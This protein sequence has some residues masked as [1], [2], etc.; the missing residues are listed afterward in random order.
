[1]SECTGNCGPGIQ[2]IKYNC[3]K[4]LHDNSISQR[5][6]HHLCS[7]LADMPAEQKCNGSCKDVRWSYGE[8]S[9]CTVTCGGGSQ[10]RKAV[11][12]SDSNREILS[13]DKC[14]S[15]KKLVSRPCN[16]DSCPRWNYA[17][18]TQVKFTVTTYIRIVTI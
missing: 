15:D 14:D 2:K 3:V 7:H 5:M 9:S 8:W 10:T 16:Q 11:C 4:I 6:P 12:V 13:D 17:G 18:W 1:M